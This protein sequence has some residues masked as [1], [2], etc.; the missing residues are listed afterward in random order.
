MTV[1]I[2]RTFLFYII[3]ILLMKMM[4]KRQIGELQLS[5]F[6]SAVMISELAVLPLTDPD[7]P[8]LHALIPLA[9]ISVF[10]VANAYLCKKSA[11]V[12]RLLDG[13][14]LILAENGKLIEENMAKARI[15]SDEI[16]SQIRIAGYE[17]LADTKRI[18]LEQ[19]GKISITPRKAR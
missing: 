7:I 12:R 8:S 14:P 1:I 15:T 18:T 16:N 13:D 5:E 4:G 3:L 6:V 19:T 17:S 9:L 11:F 10:E 2:I